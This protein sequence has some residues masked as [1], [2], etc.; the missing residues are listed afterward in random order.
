MAT[1]RTIILKAAASVIF[2]GCLIAALVFFGN[3][4]KKTTPWPVEGRPVK[5]LRASFTSACRT[6]SFPGIAQATK[7]VHLAFRVG[8]PLRGLPVEIGQFLSPGD[9]IARIDPRDYR[10]RVETLEA[11]LDSYEAKR[12]EAKLQYDRYRNLYATNA[13]PKAQYDHAKAAYDRLSAM[14]DL[15]ARE[16]QDARNALDDTALTAPFPGYVY[17]QLVENYD[18]V[19]PSQ[20]VVIFLD[21]SVMEVTVG[22]PEELVSES[23][24]YRSFACSFDAYPGKRYE[25]HLKEL[26]PKPKPSNQTYPLTVILPQ[27]A[28]ERIKP[29]MAADVHMTFTRNGVSRHILLPPEAVLHDRD[30]KTFVWVVDR[31]S[32]TVSKRFITAGSMQK[33]AI[34]VLD[35]I[36]EGDLVVSAGAH[37]LSPGTKVSLYSTEWKPETQYPDTAS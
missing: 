3:G 23:I 36:A 30:N 5:A 20:P 11:K 4:T 35:G 27:P 22:I 6:R 28:S 26:A 9:L 34:P 13:V 15:T 18:Y 33:A 14:V 25:A 2:A 8:G 17:A 1:K 16:L 37:Y 32:K 31:D 7:E 24:E 12:V 29:G 19:K 10:V 21:C